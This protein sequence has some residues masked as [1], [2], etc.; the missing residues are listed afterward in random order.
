MQKPLVFALTVCLDFILL[1][2]LDFVGT[3]LSLNGS[4]KLVRQWLESVVRWGSLHAALLLSE[5]AKGPVV[6]RWVL[7]HCFIGP[8]RNGPLDPV[9]K[10]PTREDGHVGGRQRRCWFWLLVLGDPRARLERGRQREGP[11][12]E[13]SSPLHEGDPL[14]QAR[15]P[16]YARGVRL[17]GLSCPL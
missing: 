3:H 9:W 7:A 12:S 11:E 16:Y 17:S 2:A 10:L 8:V 15:L 4:D 5:D 6:R 14:L 1:C 13:G